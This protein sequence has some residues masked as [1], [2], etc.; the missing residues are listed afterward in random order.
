VNIRKGRNLYIS[1]IEVPAEDDERVGTLV[2]AGEDSEE[3]RASVA[4]LSIPSCSQLLLVHAIAVASFAG[5]GYW[6]CSSRLAT[7]TIA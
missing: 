5:R 2:L 4:E 3:R 1:A 6:E 7:T